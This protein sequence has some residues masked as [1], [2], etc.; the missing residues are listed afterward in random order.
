MHQG[1][2]TPYA[3]ALIAFIKEKLPIHLE[4]KDYI[5]SCTKGCLKAKSTGINVL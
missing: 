2:C 3:S 1:S 5:S 4:G